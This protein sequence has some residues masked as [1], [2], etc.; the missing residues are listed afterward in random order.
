MSDIRKYD[1]YIIRCRKNYLFG[2]SMG[3]KLDIR[4]S[5]WDAWSTK[6]I[7]DARMIAARIGGKVVRFNPAEGSV[8]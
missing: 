7:Q 2:V 5:P 1:R 4:P 6:K 3:G 8:A